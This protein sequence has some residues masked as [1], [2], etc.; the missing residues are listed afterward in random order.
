MPRREFFRR[1]IFLFNSVVT[2]GPIIILLLTCLIGGARTGFFGT[3]PNWL[4]ICIS[5]LALA[6]VLLVFTVY[7]SFYSPRGGR[8]A[9]AAVFCAVAIGL[10][11]A[12][13]AA[14]VNAGAVGTAVA[15]LWAGTS[16]ADRSLVKALQ[17]AFGCC[18]WN[19]TNPGCGGDSA[20]PCAVVV[21]P[22]LDRYWSAAA[23]ALLTLA[24][25]VGALSLAGGALA[26]SPAR[27]PEER[28]VES[29][30]CEPRVHEPLVGPPIATGW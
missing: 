23:A 5:A 14:L 21:Q 22:A 30:R 24:I 2:L 27:P 8:I 4:Y 28:S 1:L 25:A 26:R 16:W 17:T 12:A 29:V 6:S 19:L 10:V 9:A 11:A 20:S 15:A 13:A 18:G 3:E 7:A